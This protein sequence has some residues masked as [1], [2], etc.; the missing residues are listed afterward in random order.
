MNIHY[1]PIALCMW[2][3]LKP[4]GLTKKFVNGGAFCDL[5]F[6]ALD[7]NLAENNESM[8]TSALPRFIE[9]DYTVLEKKSKSMKS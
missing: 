4:S 9:I 2:L 7:R 3:L 6:P 1:F 8:N 5:L